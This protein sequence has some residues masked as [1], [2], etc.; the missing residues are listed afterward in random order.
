MTQLSPQADTALSIARYYITKRMPALA[1][2]AYFPRLVVTEPGKIGGVVLTKNAKLMVDPRWV[3]D[4][5]A[6]APSP[7]MAGMQIGGAILHNLMH[8]LFR[9]DKRAAQLNVPVANLKVWNL[10]CDMAINGHLHRA[11]VILPPDYVT[12]HKYGLPPDLLPEEYYDKLLQSRPELVDEKFEKSRPADGD[13]LAAGLCGSASGREHG[14]E[15]ND[16]SEGAA[17]SEVAQTSR[18]AVRALQEEAKSRGTVAAGMLREL[19]LVERPPKVDWREH[20]SQLVR[21]AVASRKG[22][23][24]T[25]YKYQNRKQA[26]LGYGPGCARLCGLEEYEPSIAVILDTSGSMGQGDYDRAFP[27]I[28]AIINQVGGKIQF[29]SCDADVH[30][31]VLVTDDPNE[32]A[33]N[34]RGGGGTDMAPALKRCAEL[35]VR[36]HVV[37]CLTDGYIGD[38]GPEPEHFKTIWCLTQ[39][40]KECVQKFGDIVECWDEKIPGVG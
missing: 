1:G 13:S 30:G 33:K 25:T 38:P 16:N 19:D 29:L 21:E 2:L 15:E 35:K 37:I 39:N 27:E 18:S 10:A 23:N 14:E 36:P 4:T 7:E 5:I 17:P 22:A 11:N 12:A 20:L 32:I 3:D 31:E 6:T 34:I 8:M 24:D 28:A 40:Y 26:G 9:H